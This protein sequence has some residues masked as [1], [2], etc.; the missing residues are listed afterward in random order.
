M[1]M[2]VAIPHLCCKPV[3]VSCVAAE[4]CTHCVSSVC[5]LMVFTCDWSSSVTTTAM[6]SHK[7]HGNMLLSSEFIH[8][9]QA[10]FGVQKLH[11]VNRSNDG[12]WVSIKV[13]KGKSK[14]P[15]FMLSIIK[16]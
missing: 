3:V 12:P 7:N 5:S 9:F 15:K 8:N 10:F 6:A 2:S 13:A 16:I 1:T 4:T 11:S 14:V